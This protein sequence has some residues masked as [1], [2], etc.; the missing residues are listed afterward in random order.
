MARRRGPQRI[1]RLHRA[2][3]G[4]READT[5][6][7][8]MDIIVHGLGDRNDIAAQARQMRRETQRTVAAQRDQRI[9]FQRIED[10]QHLLRLV[11]LRRYPR[12]AARAVQYRA[13]LPVNAA[14]P[15][16]VEHHH[17]V[18]PRPG[19]GGIDFQHAFPAA[20]Q[21]DHVPAAL[22]GRCRDRLDAGI[23]ARDIAATGEYSQTH[24]ILPV[25]AA[26][27]PTH[28]VGASGAANQGSSLPQSFSLSKDQS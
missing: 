11:A 26:A 24:F 25:S 28:F 1:D 13:A 19:I 23:E 20:T 22:P 5:I 8:A 16:A 7:G 9:D 18:I 21:P 6:I 14:H 15:V 3:D 10:I 4:G 17:A 12:V 2:G 27:L